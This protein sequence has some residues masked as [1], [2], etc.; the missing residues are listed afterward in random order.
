MAYSRKDNDGEL[1]IAVNRWCE[2]DTIIVPER[3][4]NGKVLYGNAPDGNNLTL[5]AYSFA[6]IKI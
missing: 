2:N 4:A 3:F 6:I 1:L 5:D